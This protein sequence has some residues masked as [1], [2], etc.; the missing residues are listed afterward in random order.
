MTSL[1]SVVLLAALSPLLGQEAVVRGRVMDA[2]TSSPVSG[3]V[4]RVGDRTSTT[5]DAAGRF[6]VALP[7][8]TVL[9]VVTADGYFTESSQV[10]VNAS[11]IDLEN[12][13]V[14][15]TQIAEGITVTGVGAPIPAASEVT[16]RQVTTVAGAG[17]NIFRVLHTLPGVAA[18]DEFGSRLSVRGGGPDQNLTMMDG[19]E[20]YNPYRLFGLTSAF[21]PDTVQRFELTAG[22]FSAKYGDRLSSILV[23]GNRAGRRQARLASSAALRQELV[24][25]AAAAHVVEAGFE[26]HA[27]ALTGR[28]ASPAIAIRTRRTGPRCAPDRDFPRCSTRTG[29]PGA[30]A[31]GSSIDGPSDRGSEPNGASA[32]T[33]A[34]WPARS[35]HPRDS[36][37][38][39]TLPVVY[40]CAPPPDC[41]R[42]VRDTRSC[43]SLTILSI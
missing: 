37:R 21:N 22:G 19:I 5:A 1:A 14:A 9:L 40:A 16:P 29:R 15:R 24:I 28:G 34:D 31:H 43:C 41:S 20:I 4:V 27:L 11:G 26:S 7:A 2:A 23:V 36:L 32:S 25:Q 42:R 3:A 38:P 35:T 17:E 39:R 30:G 33:G 13:M 8:G 6:T 10:A 12:R 18:A